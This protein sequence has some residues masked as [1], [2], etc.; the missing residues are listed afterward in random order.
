M[1]IE[2]IFGPPGTG[3][4]TKL[5]DILAKELEEYEPEEIAYVSFTREGSYQGLDRAIERFGFSQKRLPWFRTLHSIAFNSLG[6]RRSDMISKDNY[7]IF[8][9]KLGMK[10]T[11]Y[12]TEDFR[13]N[14]DRYL[15]FDILHR[16]NPKTAASYLHDMDMR[17]LQFVRTNYKRFKDYF[18]IQDF[19]D[20]I[21]G[22]NKKNNALPVKVAF[23]DEAQDLTTLQW[24]MIWVAFRDCDK[25]YI[26][27]DDDQAIYEWSGADVHYFLNLKGNQTI[28]NKSY[29][30]PKRIL[31]YSKKI[32]DL[33]Q[34][35]VEK[36][37][38]GL[39][40]DGEVFLIN[41]IEELSLTKDESWLF[42][43]RNHYFLN[44]II[45]YLKSKSHIF[46]HRK[47]LSVSKQKVAAINLFESIR[48]DM[49]MSLDQERVLQKHYDGRR[50]NLNRPWY[51]NFTW[52]V[53]EIMYYRDLIA[54]KV[55]LDECNITV[56][57]IHS[58][59]GSEADNV[60][61]F[62]DITKQVLANFQNNPDSERRV[63]YV[64]ATRAKKRLYIVSPTNRYEFPLRSY[65]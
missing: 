4:T 33:I 61:L 46:M 39:E 18:Q 17:Q 28:L 3:K 49:I 47:D 13:H 34:Y 6:L 48:K 55:K 23:I 63:F 52:D 5:Q 19:T 29:R 62:S 36:D 20:I 60:V 35:R 41:S 56:D 7:K 57:T 14:D 50:L 38:H 65:L 44:Q 11:G 9:D 2:I 31:R 12:Y 40:D 32:S 42:L 15:F 64:G 43:S 54:N 37:Y 21:E 16:N 1:D 8:S 25:I 10:F 26:A 53:E 27:G 51:M 30:L 45:K 58:V 22:F 59:K 24:K